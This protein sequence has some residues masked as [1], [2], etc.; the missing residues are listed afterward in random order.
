MV[1]ESKTHNIK[2]EERER[3]REETLVGIV[4][5]KKTKPVNYVS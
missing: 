5:M 3:E 1:L 4:V 2:K